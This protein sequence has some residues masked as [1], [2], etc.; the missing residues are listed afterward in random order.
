MNASNGNIIPIPAAG[1]Q[2]AVVHAWQKQEEH[3]LNINGQ[4]IWVPEYVA[5]LFDRFKCIDRTFAKKFVLLYKQSWWYVKGFKRKP[6]DQRDQDIAQFDESGRFPFGGVSHAQWSVSFSLW[7]KD[8]APGKFGA[9]SICL[10]HRELRE[11]ASPP[12][13]IT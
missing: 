1:V 5:V 10:M 2:I 3:L 9:I 6:Q 11:N 7:L 4:R 8:F 13:P 12:Q